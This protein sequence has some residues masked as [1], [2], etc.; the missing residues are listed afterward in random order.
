MVAKTTVEMGVIEKDVVV[1]AVV[2]VTT[3]PLVKVSTLP[4]VPSV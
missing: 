4:D 1:A 3:T 2:M